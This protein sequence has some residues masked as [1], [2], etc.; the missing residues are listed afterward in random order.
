MRAI[1]C[2]YWERDDGGHIL[3][4]LPGAPEIERVRRYLNRR[5]WPLEIVALHGSLSAREQDQALRNEG[6]RRVI[7][8]TNIAETSLTIDGVSA[9]V[10]SGYHKQMSYEPQRGI[11]RLNLVRISRA[12]ATQRAGRAGR[13][14]AGRVIR[15]WE[16]QV[17]HMLAAEDVAEIHRIDL[18][19]YLLPVI[20]FHGPAVAEFPFFDAPTDMVVSH[21]CDIL[22]LLGARRWR[23]HLGIPT[24]GT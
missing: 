14:R 24:G 4:F 9:V 6:E 2:N 15:L 17:Q 22:Q 21:A 12:S 10:D 1:S 16:E 11:N 20:D 19:D 3:V 5:D 13:Q 18:S 7:L 8:A 23:P